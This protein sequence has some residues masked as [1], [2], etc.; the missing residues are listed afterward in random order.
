MLFSIKNIRTLIYLFIFT[1]SL[2]E[3]KSIEASFEVY[4]AQEAYV[5]IARAKAH[6]LNGQGFVCYVKKTTREVSVLCNDVNTTE[7]L[8]AISE[9]FKKAGIEFIVK[10]KEGKIIKKGT[11]KSNYFYYGYTAYDNKDYVKAE[12]IFKNYYKQENSYEHAYAYSLALDKNKKY[13]DVL[14][15][16]SEYRQY[17]KAKKLYD[18]NLLNY[19]NP[20]LEKG[21]FKQAHEIVDKYASENETLLAL[22][23]EKEEQYSVK[24][25]KFDKKNAIL[26]KKEEHKRAQT[27]YQS[28]SKLTVTKGTNSY[29]NDIY[30]SIEQNINRREYSQAKYTLE[31]AKSIYPQDVNILILEMNLYEQQSQF[32]KAKDIAL[33]LIESNKDSVEVEYVLAVN[34]FQNY[35]YQSCSERLKNLKFNALEQEEL[36]N[37]CDAYL[38]VEHNDIKRAINS[39]TKVSNNH[40]KAIFYLN[41][42]ELYRH[43]N[44]EIALSY[45]H[46]AKKYQNSIGRDNMY[47]KASSVK[48]PEN[49]TNDERELYRYYRSQNYE[50]CYNFSHMMEKSNK[51]RDVVNMQGWCAYFVGEYSEAKDLFGKS[52]RYFG[53]SNRDIYAYA[54]ST[55][56]AG[57]YQRASAALRRMNGMKSSKDVLSIALLYIDL[58]DDAAAKQVLQRY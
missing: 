43:E 21:E 2:S 19:L 9:Q 27:T 18:V 53:E 56:Q 25:E 17:S 24:K 10:D 28:A 29:L 8:E 50:V 22:V 20:K 13:K 26:L 45:L 3:G 55:Y 35:N 12:N 34:D 44:I 39:I 42:G 52:N 54:L 31:Y 41:I 7:A 14:D 1:T 57:D 58:G 11:K 23:N 46:Q 40:K 6:K 47:L 16:L 36:F 33:Q 30:L 37:Q 5:N 49:M 15:V 38:N 51:K 48:N 32:S 4:H